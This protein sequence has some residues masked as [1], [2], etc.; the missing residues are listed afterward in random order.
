MSHEPFFQCIVTVWYFFIICPYH[1]LL[2]WKDKLL[3]GKMFWCH[4]I[5]PRIVFNVMY[6]RVQLVPRIRWVWWW[7]DLDHIYLVETLVMEKVWFTDIHVHLQSNLVS[8]LKTSAILFWISHLDKTS[9][10]RIKANNYHE[11]TI[12]FE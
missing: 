2:H 8:K 7:M 9:K 4:H 3:I 6:F 1:T 12:H 10:V 11:W 5:I